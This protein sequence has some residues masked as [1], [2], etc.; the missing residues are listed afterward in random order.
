ME[1]GSSLHH[2]GSAMPL[3]DLSMAY[4]S[5][6]AA[7]KRA[8]QDSILLANRIRL[9]RAEEERT[10]KK[11]REAERQAYELVD[12]RRR[13]EERRQ[14][15]EAER[16]RREAERQEAE[17]Q[18][19]RERANKQ[20]VIAEKQLQIQNEKSAMSNM[21]RQERE[22][23]ERLL[24]EERQLAQAVARQRHER[25][26]NAE[27]AALHSRARSEDCKRGLRQTALQEKLGREEE[28]HRELAAEVARMEREEAELIA[29][30]ERSQM[31]HQHAFAQL[32]DARRGDV[33]LEM[34]RPPTGPTSSGRSSLQ[35]SHRGTPS[36]SSSRP[37]QLPSLTSSGAASRLPPAA[38]HPQQHGPPSAGTSSSRGMLKSSSAPALQAQRAAPATKGHRGGSAA[39]S[40]CSTA[41]GTDRGE[42]A[43]GPCTPASDAR[44]AK[45]FGAAEQPAHDQ[46]SA[47]Q[48]AQQRITYTTADGDQ[49]EIAAEEEL[50]LNALLNA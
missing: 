3:G 41:F 8:E 39:A 18:H 20:N 12:L 38:R 11:T 19:F 37:P 30:L 4:N 9:L 25:V 48:L 5:A 22:A 6:A 35:H 43:S 14:A 33:S 15:E 49:L 47:E 40:S 7:R 31:R 42:P 27:M 29:R 28:Q 50:D 23:G 17:L 26:R 44:L 32:E 24:Q 45:G 2:S 21:V 1:T 16:L 34:L 13:N 46:P 10:H 36:G